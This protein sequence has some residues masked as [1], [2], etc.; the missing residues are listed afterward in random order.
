M[1]GFA[2][3]ELPTF[4]EP[5]LAPSAIASRSNGPWK[6]GKWPHG[7]TAE[8]EDRRCRYPVSRQGRRLE[9]LVTSAAILGVRPPAD[10][11]LGMSLRLCAYLAW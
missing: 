7:M 6:L 2:S 10:V 5:G 9:R 1:S 8:S 4:K 11:L 3:P